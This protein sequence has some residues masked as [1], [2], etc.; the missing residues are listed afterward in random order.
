MDNQD[1]LTQ[2]VEAAPISVA[3]VPVRDLYRSFESLG[4]NCEFG[5]VQ[6]SVGYDPPGLF[7]NVGFNMPSAIINAI[8]AHLDG[9]FDEGRYKYLRQEGWPDWRLDCNV[10]GFYFHSGVSVSIL[11]GTP[12]WTKAMAESIAAFRFLKRKF[13]EELEYG[14]KIFTFRYLPEQSDQTIRRLYAAIRSHGPGRLLFVMQDPTK[15]FAWTQ[16]L[17]EGLMHAAIGKLS[18]ENPPQVDFA[19]WEAIARKAVQMLDS[20]VQ[21][22]LAQAASE[23]DT[24]SRISTPVEF[25]RAVVV[26]SSTGRNAVVV[27]HPDRLVSCFESLGDGCELG[28]VQRFCGME[29][30]GLLRFAS[31]PYIHLVHLLKTNFVELENPDIVGV[32]ARPEDDEWWGQV[33]GFGIYYHTARSASGVTRADV[34]ADERR[35]VPRLREKLADQLSDPEKIFVRFE[36]DRTREEIQVV[37]AALREHGEHS[38]LWILAAK[39]PSQ[40]GMIELHGNGLA[41]GYVKQPS[42]NAAPTP[43]RLAVWLEML[44]KALTLLQPEVAASLDRQ[45]TGEAPRKIATDPAHWA[46][47]PEGMLFVG[48]PDR[49]T[50]PVLFE[51][52]PIIEHELAVDT[53]METGIVLAFEATGLVPSALYVVS[54]WV[55]VPDDYD[56]SL[57]MVFPGS[58]SLRGW[59]ADMSQRNCWQR[60]TTC[61]RLPADLTHHYPGILALG[62]AGQRFYSTRWRF[63]R[64][65]VP[66]ECFMMNGT[67]VS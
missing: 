50:V 62:K 58:V 25:G 24:S 6:R 23:P 26:E 10:Y 4:N 36:I 35:R 64:G 5:I 22:S 56:G 65:V 19:A 60:V 42:P 43:K 15:P 27:Q 29:P 7:R 45:L 34:L 21:A 20:D 28:M 61:F 30:L 2:S 13:L 16:R 51:D 63:E 31:L 18:N 54:A 55:W 32:V 40:I 8:E 67:D 59:V 1:E 46:M 33:K 11:E 17:D 9:M 37:H 14:D 12:E 41:I 39:E 44:Q 3:E 57:G 47:K 52:D 66:D 48:A 38:L 49:K 53:G